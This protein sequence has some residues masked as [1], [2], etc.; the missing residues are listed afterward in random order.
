MLD[1]LDLLLAGGALI[2]EQRVVLKQ[3]V[4]ERPFQFI[5]ILLLFLKHFSFAV[6][7]S[8]LELQGLIQHL[9]LSLQILHLRQRARVCRIELAF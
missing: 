9:Q 5:D 3:L 6:D 1:L 7:L 8:F 4:L 2:L